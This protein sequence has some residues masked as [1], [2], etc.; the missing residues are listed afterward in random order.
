MKTLNSYAQEKQTALFNSMGAFFAF[1]NEQL[2][3]KRKEG[4]EYVN[5]GNGLIAPKENAQALYDGL[6]NIHKESVAEDLK[7]NGKK[8]IIRRELF[9]YECF[10]VGN[11]TDCV[12]ALQDYGITKEEIQEHYNHISSTEDVW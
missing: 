9:N 2:N 12:E 3:E 1:S 4:V 11:I 8:A 10:L 6:C 5:L 7:E